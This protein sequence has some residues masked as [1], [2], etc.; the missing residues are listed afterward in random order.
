MADLSRSDKLEAVLWLTRK[1]SPLKEEAFWMIMMRED[2]S[3]CCVGIFFDDDEWREK[4]K[5]ALFRTDD[6]NNVSCVFVSLDKRWWMSI[7][8]IGLRLDPWLSMEL[9]C[10]EATMNT[11]S[12]WQ[13]IFTSGDLRVTRVAVDWFY[14]LDFYEQDNV[15]SNGGHV[16]EQIKRTARY[17]S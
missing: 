16:V 15:S 11:I 17:K 10:H 9:Y 8:I 1:L 6:K 5:V 13:C 12:Q 7:E 2:W 3:S 4:R 14:A